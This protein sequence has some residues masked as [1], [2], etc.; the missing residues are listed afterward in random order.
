MESS[1]GT[2]VASCRE[3]P[4]QKAPLTPTSVTTK[5]LGINIFIK[6]CCCCY[7]CFSFGLEGDYVSDYQTPTLSKSSQS[8]HTK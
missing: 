5:H 4:K 2:G 1:P 6:V 7:C 8:H 3:D